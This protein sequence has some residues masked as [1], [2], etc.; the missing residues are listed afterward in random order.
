MTGKLFGKT[1]ILSRIS[2]NKTLEGFIGGMVLTSGLANVA[3]PFLVP[4]GSHLLYTLGDWPL[5]SREP[6]EI[7][8][9][10]PL[11]EVPV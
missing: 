6:V 3:G 5:V 1:K 7:F 8:I 11:K 2:P 10:H 9:C 4:E